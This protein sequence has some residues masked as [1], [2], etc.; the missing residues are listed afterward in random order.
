[1]PRRRTMWHLVCTSVFLPNTSFLGLTEALNRPSTSFRTPIG[2][3][4]IILSKDSLK[5]SKNEEPQY[6]LGP[7]PFRS[8]YRISAP[9]TSS[10]TLSSSVSVSLKCRLHNPMA[11][12]QVVL[13]ANR[14]RVEHDIIARRK[15]RPPRPERSKTHCC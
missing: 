3:A 14:D 15:R 1:S 9:K 7:I 5:S 6:R 12:A 4:A 2:C 13:E 11:S 8:L 10:P